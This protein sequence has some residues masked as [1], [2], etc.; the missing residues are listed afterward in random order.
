[1]RT[2]DDYRAMWATIERLWPDTVARAG[3]LPEPALHLRVD[4]EWSFVETLRH[5]VFATDAWAGRTI[6][7]EPKA[8]LT[9]GSYP[10]A[11]AD[12]DDA[13][14]ADV[15]DVG[16]LGDV[17]AEVVGVGV[18]VEVGA[19]VVGVGVGAL[20]VGEAGVGDGEA[21]ERW[22]GDADA[23]WEVRADAEA[24][25]LAGCDVPW[26]DD[27]AALAEEDA[28]REAAEEE[29]DAEPDTPG[30]PRPPAVDAA[31]ED[32]S[33]AGDW[34]GVGV[35]PPA[36]EVTAKPATPAAIMPAMIHTST[37]GRHKRRCGRLLPPG[38]G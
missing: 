9:W 29:E 32:V 20:D 23:D 10:D 4:D 27:A 21:D 38:G 14:P 26:N 13:V 33:P 28:L 19:D 36:K 25:A 11:G 31:A 18:G 7:D 24:G 1:M 12:A 35:L 37:I 16:V 34:L 8:F 30:A 22:L 17:G 5:L 3:R 6:L 15:A 2:G